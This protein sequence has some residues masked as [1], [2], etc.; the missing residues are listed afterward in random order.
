MKRTMT[1]VLFLLALL[2]IAGG[3]IGANALVHF[4][5][6]YGWTIIMVAAAVAARVAAAREVNDGGVCMLYILAG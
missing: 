2:G 6:G 1:N 3:I 4:Y 5:P